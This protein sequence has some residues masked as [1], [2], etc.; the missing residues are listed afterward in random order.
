MFGVSKGKGVSHGAPEVETKLAER[1]RAGDR[2][3][4]EALLREHAPTLLGMCQQIVGRSEA[5]DAL[6][7]ALARIARE[8]S[9]YDPSKGSFKSWAC[10]VTRNVCRDRLRRLGR[11]R[12]AFAP[13]G[14]EHVQAASAHDADPERHAIA[15]EGAHSL[16]ASL[17]SLPEDMR[18][19]LVLFHVHD[20]SYEEIARALDVPIGTIM[21]WL[22]RG[23]KRL[24]EALKER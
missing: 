24:R 22:H 7:S 13:D 9:Q 20:A 18:T 15:R 4:L 5:R 17:E 16:G 6:Q 10:T 11:E 2:A 12:K 19:A 23:R 3:A 1:A 21:T 14:A 8:V